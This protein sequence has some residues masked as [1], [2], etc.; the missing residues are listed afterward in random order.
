MKFSHFKSLG[1]I[2][3]VLVAFSC[4]KE[5]E[6]PV[7]INNSVFPGDFLSD[8]KYTK[9]LI[10]A[11]FVDGYEP[12]SVSL[13]NLVGFLEQHLNKPGGI[14]VIKRLIPSPGRVTVDAG[15]MREF[16]KT[17]RQEV[18]GGDQITVWLMFLDTDYSSTA[19]NTKVLGVAYAPS[20]IA[21]FEKTVKSLGGG[22]YQPPTSSLE[23]TVLTHEFG[24]ILGL[25][26]NGTSMVSPHQDTA[27]NAH[28]SDPDCLM[29]YKAETHN[30]GDYIIG[31]GVPQ[32]DVN[33]V[34]DLKAAGGK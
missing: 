34:A 6:S 7:V 19:G 5:V 18:T 25:V 32:L 20:S 33:C 9:V 31:G 1:L 15:F 11:A 13:D 26:N 22:G 23:T 12:T 4:D 3:L 29:Y 10:E 24:H 30:V 27:N 21:V 14:A 8:K 2:L 28:C 16:E 17:N